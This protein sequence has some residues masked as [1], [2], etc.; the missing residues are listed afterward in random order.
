M[1]KHT[2]IHPICLCGW[3]SLRNTLPKNIF[4][5]FKF[6]GAVNQAFVSVLAP[7]KGSLWLHCHF[8]QF[9]WDVVQLL[10]KLSLIVVPMLVEVGGKGAR[11][12]AEG[13]WA[14]PVVVGC[15]FREPRMVAIL[16]PDRGVLGVGRVDWAIGWS[17]GEGYC[18]T[19]TGH[20][21][22][23]GVGGYLIGL[24]KSIHRPSAERAC[25]LMECLLDD[26]FTVV[27]LCVLLSCTQIKSMSEVY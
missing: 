10:L 27:T 1:P 13:S 2:C 12:V 5:I 26:W 14:L 7:L 16:S 22:A 25:N 11:P 8:C 18:V 17:A 4:L 21:I 6:T 19:T 3:T 23:G 15:R 9:M 20:V 24:T